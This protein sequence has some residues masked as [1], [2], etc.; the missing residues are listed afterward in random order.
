MSNYFT[1]IAT[2]IHW[3]HFCFSTLAAFQLFPSSAKSQPAWREA[4]THIPLLI[5][6]HLT[7]WALSLSLRNWK[8]SCGLLGSLNAVSKW[9]DC[10]LE[11]AK[12]YLPYWKNRLP[13]RFCF[14]PF[15]S[16]SRVKALELSSFN[17]NWPSTYPGFCGF[18][19]YSSWRYIAL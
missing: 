10:L 16:L 4:A 13:E 14:S 11:L 6:I 17:Q 3:H 15:F 1:L 5:G 2:K 7:A 18:H 19:P 9:T 8:G 12:F